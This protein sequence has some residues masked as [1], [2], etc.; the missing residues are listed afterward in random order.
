MKH[1][2]HEKQDSM[3]YKFMKLQFENPKKG[4]WVSSCL[5]D[6]EY[7]EIR[8]SLSELQSLNKKEFKKIIENCIKIK[9][10]EYLMGKRGRKGIEI[11]YSHLKMAEYL[12]PNDDLSI[13]EQRYIFS[14][15]NRMIKIENNY[16]GTKNK[17]ICFCGE[18]EDMNHIYDCKMFNI[19]NE[20]RL[21]YEN[22]FGE[23]LKKMKIIYERFRKN[24]EKRENEK[25]SPRILNVDPLYSN[26]CTAMEIN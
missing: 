13:S 24:F 3:L 11:N 4:D 12:L 21:P 5:Q 16:R 19:K 22:I 20:E 17:I 2:L 25:S 26:H 18:F 10:F 6:L 7:L 9:S 23:D 8:I 14:I 15:R 1:I